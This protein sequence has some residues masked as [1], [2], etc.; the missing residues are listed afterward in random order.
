MFNLNIVVKLCANKVNHKPPSTMRDEGTLFRE[1]AVEDYST[2]LSFIQKL[3]YRSA[4]TMYTLTEGQTWTKTYNKWR[5]M[6]YPFKL[7]NYPLKR[8]IDLS[9]IQ[10]RAPSPKQHSQTAN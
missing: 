8:L 6:R 2:N 9:H 10:K 4:T 1:Y 3:N 7:L 5:S